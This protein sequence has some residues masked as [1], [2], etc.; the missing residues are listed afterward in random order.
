VKT[1][2]L[3]NWLNFEILGTTAAFGPFSD[4]AEARLAVSSPCGNE[5]IHFSHIKK[6]FVLK[7]TATTLITG[8]DYIDNDNPA[9]LEAPGGSFFYFGHFFAHLGSI[10]TISVQACF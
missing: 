5:Y 7:K 6:C 9:Y 8:D 10:T 1:G 4:Y 3:V 2:K